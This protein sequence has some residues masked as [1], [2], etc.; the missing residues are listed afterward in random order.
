MRARVERVAVGQSDAA[1]HAIL[2][3]DPVQRPGHPED[4]YPSPRRTLALETPIGGAL[5]LELYVVTARAAEGCPDVQRSRRSAGR[6]SRQAGARGAARSTRCATCATPTSAPTCRP[7]K[8]RR[9]RGATRVRR[10]PARGVAR[11]RARVPRRSGP[12]LDP[13]ERARVGGRERR[14][15]RDGDARH[16]ATPERVHHRGLLRRGALGAALLAARDPARA[17]RDG[18][19]L[20]RRARPTRGRSGWAADAD[21]A[22]APARAALVSRGARRRSAPPGPRRRIGAARA[23]PRAL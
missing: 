22:R 11:A 20:V 17:A 3:R 5:V 4:P 23:D 16:A 6:M 19:A 12:P 1:A 9:D 7:G 13:A 2:G 18:G 15:L 21:R 10:R 14:L 8:T